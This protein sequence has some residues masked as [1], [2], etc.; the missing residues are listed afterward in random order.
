VA[1]TVVEGFERTPSPRAFIG[2]I[3]NE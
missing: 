2:R 3:L 1:I